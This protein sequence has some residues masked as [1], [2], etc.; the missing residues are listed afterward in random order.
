[1]ADVV[2][3]EGFIEDFL[4][5]ALRSKRDEIMYSVDLLVSFPEIGS[6]HTPRSIAQLYGGNVRKLV[7]DSFDVAYEYDERRDEAHILGLIHQRAAW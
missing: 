5:V 3:T 7:V 4:H 1:M 2:Y 6:S